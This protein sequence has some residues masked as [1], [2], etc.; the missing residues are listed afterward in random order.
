MGQGK[1]DQETLDLSILTYSVLVLLVITFTIVIFFIV[2]QKR[3]NQLILDKL[4]QQQKF[5]EELAKTQ[6]EIQEETLKHVGRELHDNV[7]QL[8]SFATMQMNAAA[9]V[10]NEEVKSKVNNASSALKESLTEVRA[11]SKSLNTDVIFN[12]GLEDAV[13][14]EIN[15]LNKS[16]LMEAS[17]DIIGEKINFQ[18]QKDAIIL[19][20]IIQE[21]FSNTLKY[22]EA[23]RLKISLDYQP[24]QLNISIQDDGIGFDIDKAEQGSGMTNMKKRAELINTVFQLK[25]KV[26]KG[27]ELQLEYPYFKS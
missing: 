9:K 7:G 24:K 11:L 13:Q 18:N 4:K 2:F 3:K 22:A 27:T 26:D 6:Q 25:S 15:R 16:G 10:V 14:N 8:L 20:R 19:F 21:F 12:L 1:I 23:D 5:D 17:F